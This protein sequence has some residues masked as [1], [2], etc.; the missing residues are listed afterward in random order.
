MSALLAPAVAPGGCVVLADINAAMMEVGRDRL[1]DE[2]HPDVRFCRTSA[3][4][5]SFASDSF[6]CAT[7]A[8]GLRN[9]TDKLVAFEELLRVL[10]PGG[11]LV[12]LEFS[13]PQH[14]LLQSAY[15]AFQTFWPPIGRLVVN[16]DHSYRYLVESIAVHPNQE[17][18]KLMMEDAGFADVEY[19][20]LAGGIAAIHTGVA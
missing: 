18:L 12:V 4:E 17:G 1:L 11:T 5:L 19:H 7:I 10:R 8:F 14:P 9:F 16:D 3:E 20:N 2:G 15:Q 6:D 13:K